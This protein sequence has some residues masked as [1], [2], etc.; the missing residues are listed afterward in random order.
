MNYLLRHSIDDNTRKGGWSRAKLTKDGIKL[1]EEVA[2]KLKNFHFDRIICSDLVR[3]KETAKII[4]KEL[5]LPI[6]YTDELREFNAGVVS[7]MKYDK[8]N[9]LYPVKVNDYK[10]LDFKYPK[11]ET[12]G[13]FKSRVEDYYKNTIKN[14]DK[15]LFV[16]H[17][18]TISVIYNYINKTEWNFNDKKTIDISHCSLFKVSDRGISKVDLNK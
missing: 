10:N 11:G 17:R 16:T 4:N 13:E 7:G 5:K 3:A 1:A 12:L 14:T 2:K 6:F 8:A 18:N 15:T 9:K